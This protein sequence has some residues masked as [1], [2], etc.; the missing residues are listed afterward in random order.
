M[1]LTRLP[2]IVPVVAAG[3]SFAWVGVVT[4]DNLRTGIVTALSVIAAATLVR[5]A[6]G[7]PFANPDHFE[8]DEVDKVIGAVKQLARALRLLLGFTLATMF[9]VI[10]ASSLVSGLAKVPHLNSPYVEKAV[11][12]ITAAMLS[13]VV[14]RIWQVVGSDISLLD[15]Q[16]RFLSRAVHRKQG[17]KFEEQV[18]GSNIP[19][20][21]TPEGYGKRL[22]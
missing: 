21:K 8:P 11:S 7:L 20:F 19:P 10:V 16:A 2:V 5:L 9:L 12:A 14:V 18:E 15:E 13:Y 4:W 17:K 1:T 22:Q 3:A 6:R